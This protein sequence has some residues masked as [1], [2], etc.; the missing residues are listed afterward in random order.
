[1]NASDTLAGIP[2][3]VLGALSMAF[4]VACLAGNHSLVRVMAEDMHPTQIAALRFA[5]AVPLLLPWILRN[6]AVLRTRRHALHFGA[7][8]LTVATTA[9][10]FLALSLL[11]LALATALNFSAPLFTTILAALLLKERVEGLRWAATL[12][13]FTGVLIVLRP[14][15]G[16]GNPAALLPVGSALL[17]AFW[18]LSLRRLGA[19]EST[20]TVTIYQTL[21]AAPLL[22]LLALP[23]WQAPDWRMIFYGVVLAALGTAAIFFMARAFELAD[24]SLVAP[25]DYARLPCIALIAYFAFGEVPDI[26]TIVGGAVI[27]GAAIFIARREALAKE[28]APPDRV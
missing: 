5:F 10:L 27:I 19:S 11:P 18:F 13:G 6:P 9:T 17:L 3:P 20:A 24:A 12:V 22:V 28:A 4:G 16:D 8:L 14:G 25:F 7:A 23:F 26:F 2:R 15:F 1:M 21:W